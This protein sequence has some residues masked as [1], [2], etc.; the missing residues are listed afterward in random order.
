MDVKRKKVF[1]H[2]LT[3]SK[4][5]RINRTLNVFSKKETHK[6]LFYYPCECQIIIN[7]I[8]TCWCHTYVLYLTWEDKNSL[9]D[10]IKMVVVKSTM[11]MDH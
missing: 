5:L 7:K 10:F 3:I 4:N 2:K 8:I 1:V 9:K 6:S 11:E